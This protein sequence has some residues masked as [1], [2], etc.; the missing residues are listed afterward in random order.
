MTGIVGTGMIAIGFYGY[1]TAFFN[2]SSAI[3]IFFLSRG[4]PGIWL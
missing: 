1:I 4:L 3:D 2:R